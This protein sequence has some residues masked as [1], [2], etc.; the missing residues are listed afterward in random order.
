MHIKTD[1][2]TQYPLITLIVSVF[3]ALLG[4]MVVVIPTL[5]PPS[6]DIQLLVIFMTSS[7]LLTVLLAYALYRFGLVAW[8]RSLRWTLLA[9]IVITVLLVFAN[10]WVTAQLMFITLHD[11][12]LTTGLLIFAAF[13]AVTFGFFIS[14]AI[15]ESIAEM[16]LATQRMAKGDFS[17]RVEVQG[18]DEL[19]QLAEAF[20]AMARSLQE[21]EAQKQQLDQARRD[22]I[23]W[24][25][26][27]LRTPLTSI[28]VMIEALTD[29]V[30]TDP[31]T[32]SRY[33]ENM[34]AEISHLSNLIDDLFEL[35][36]L[37]A[38][39]LQMDWVQASLSDL[40]SDTLGSMRT[41]AMQRQIDLQG[42]VE[43]GVD[44]IYMAPDKVQRVLYNL[45]HNAIVYTPPAGKITLTAR[46]DD[47]ERVYVMV[48]NTGA[49]ISSGDLPRIFESFY[50]GE[51]S[52]AKHGLG[53]RGAG[54]GLAIARGFVEAHR[55]KIWVES[56]PG[57]GTTFT[58]TLPRSRLA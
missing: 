24:V 57:E 58:F 28:R 8:F 14:S 40:I 30:V 27:D 43:T 7:G 37:D 53:H 32:M 12:V 1:R 49:E 42:H 26:H 50:R 13:I 33:F 17:T 11:L 19:A 9:T 20:N 31:E 10:V 52:R 35:A 46:P 23:A 38:G 6:Q 36:Q 4:A 41:Q 39:H 5:N 18:N 44:P 51:P 54:L 45:L 16:A 25:S 3:L 22:L 21:I 2:L 15:T 29:G 47:N 55:G 56:A 48:H 34:Q